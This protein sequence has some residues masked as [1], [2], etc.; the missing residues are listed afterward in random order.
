MVSYEDRGHAKYS[1]IGELADQTLDIMDCRT[2]HEIKYLQQTGQTN[3]ELWPPG[4]LVKQLEENPPPHYNPQWKGEKYLKAEYEEFILDESKPIIARVCALGMRIFLCHHEYSRFDLAEKGKAMLHELRFCIQ[5]ED[6]WAELAGADAALLYDMVRMKKKS[7]DECDP[8]PQFWFYHRIKPDFIKRQLV[9]MLH[10]DG[11]DWD[12]EFAYIFGLESSPRVLRGESP[13]HWEG[14]DPKGP[15]DWGPYRVLNGQNGAT[16]GHSVA[17]EE[18]AE[19]SVEEGS[20]VEQEWDDEGEELEEMEEDDEIDGV[21]EEYD[22]DEEGDS[23]DLEEI[24]ADAFREASI[25]REVSLAREAELARDDGARTPSSPIEIT[26]SQVINQA[27][28]ALRDIEFSEDDRKSQMSQEENGYYD[29]EMDY[30]EEESFY[31]E[32][33]TLVP[34]DQR[35][36]QAQV[37]QS[38]DEGTEREDDDIDHDDDREREDYTEDGEDDESIADSDDLQILDEQHL[39]GLA[40]EDEA[41]EGLHCMHREQPKR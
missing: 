4:T 17:Q 38:E 26:G 14:F 39:G 10:D 40:F 9:T 19:E 8:R 1:R 27:A 16:N 20:G 12:R 34:G 21:E 28:N 6:D 13:V 25:A 24:S 2:D 22:E 11:Y 18:S 36:S 32:D 15:V 7:K 31:D 33:D 29:E 37:P 41:N 35:L 30:D 23:S 3:F 5:G